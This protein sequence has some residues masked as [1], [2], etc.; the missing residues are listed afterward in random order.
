MTE[1]LDATLE[2]E[3]IE[4]EE[5][6]PRERKSLGSYFTWW[7]NAT[8]ATKITYARLALIPLVLFFYL[9]ANYIG[10]GE[11]GFLFRYG[12]LI[13]LIIF[14]VAAATDYLDGWVARKFNQVS[15]TGKFLDPI[16]D[17]ILVLC[18]FVLVATDPMFGNLM[19]GWAAVLIVFIAISRDY[20][21]EVVRNISMTKGIVVAAD[22]VAKWKTAF[23]LVALS[24][25]MLYVSILHLNF[26]EATLNDGLGFDILRYSAW[27]AMIVA[28]TLTIISCTNYVVKFQIQMRNLAKTE[29]E[30]EE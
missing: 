2:M 9:G 20:I 25:F 22:K 5:S 19:P 11:N 12:K 28:S 10:T 8:T 21:V 15:D 24:L 29:T 4:N 30:E 18:A 14:L 7:T 23:Q 1:E 3:E 27:S 6:L 16:C 13:A 17:K 26:S